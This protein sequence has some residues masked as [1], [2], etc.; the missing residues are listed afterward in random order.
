MTMRG[1]IEFEVEE[2]KFSLVPLKQK[3]AGMVF[4]TVLAQLVSALSGAFESDKNQLAGITKALGT[5]DYEIL[6]RLA[7]TLCEGAL[8]N[9]NEIKSLEDIEELS[10]KPWILYKIIYEGVRGNWPRVFFDLEAKIKGF[11]SKIPGQTTE[12]SKT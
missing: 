7:S 3:K 2:I 12:E 4:H 8:I 1:D 5:V 11:V 6:W 10:E 9:G